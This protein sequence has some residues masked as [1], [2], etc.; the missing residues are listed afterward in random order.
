[1]LKTNVWVDLKLMCIISKLEYMDGSLVENM[2][3]LYSF[4]GRD[5]TSSFFGKKKSKLITKNK[6]IAFIYDTDF[7]L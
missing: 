4:S 3:V 2:P 1:M 7:F 6:K 5:A